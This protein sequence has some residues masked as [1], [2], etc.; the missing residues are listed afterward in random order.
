[1]NQGWRCFRP[2]RRLPRG[3]HCLGGIA[4]SERIQIGAAR[5]GVPS[6]D[7]INPFDSL[8][9]ELTPVRGSCTLCSS[10]HSSGGV[11][12][13]AWL[14]APRQKRP[15]NGV[16]NEKNRLFYVPTGF[17][18]PRNL[19]TSPCLCQSATLQ[20]ITYCISARGRE[21]THSELPPRRSHRNSAGGH[22]L[23]LRAGSYPF[24][25]LDRERR[26]IIVSCLALRDTRILNL[27]QRQ[28]LVR[29]LTLAIRSV[30]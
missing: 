22:E 14:F 13:C 30:V 5:A 16:R 18:R 8:A 24:R 23:Q 27:F 19:V 11:C 25:R 7:S 1:M 6:G 26:L 9:I 28:C 12:T 15:R 4:C 3:N 17:Q 10:A 29:A 20:T 21:C 2:A